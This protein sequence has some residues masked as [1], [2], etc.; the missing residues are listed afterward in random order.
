MRG[1]GLA[2]RK[3]NWVKKRGVD[4]IRIEDESGTI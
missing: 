4:E 2:E 3:G 1:Y